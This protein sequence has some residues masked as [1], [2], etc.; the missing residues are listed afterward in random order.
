MEWRQTNQT[1]IMKIPNHTIIPVLAI[2]AL[3]PM[4]GCDRQKAAIDD[5]NIANKE[6]IDV[7]KD[8]V[9]AAAKLATEQTAANAE[10]DKARIEAN[11]IAMQAQLDVDK[12]IADA[13]ALAAKAQLDAERAR[14]EA[15]DDNT[16]E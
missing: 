2:T 9:D 10:L 14:A 12:K 13:E 5:T 7:R 16:S 4:L 11:K 1:I 8:Q 3:L 6:A 15:A